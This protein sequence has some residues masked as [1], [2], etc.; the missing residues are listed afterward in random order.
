MDG[1]FH[2]VSGS[3]MS[4]GLGFSGSNVSYLSSSSS[5]P[6]P[7]SGRQRELPTALPPPPP[8]KIWRATPPKLRRRP[9]AAP[10][11]ERRRAVSSRGA[12]AP[13]GRERRQAA[14]SPRRCREHRPS[15]ERHRELHKPRAFRCEVRRR[16]PHV[17]GS[18]ALT[19]V[20]SSDA[21]RELLHQPRVSSAAGGR[22]S[23]AGRTRAPLAMAPAAAT[24]TS[25]RCE[26]KREAGETGA[27][28]PSTNGSV[29]RILR[30]GANPH[31]RGIFPRELLRCRC[32]HPNSR[33]SGAAPL[34]SRGSPT[35]HTVRV[36][37]FTYGQGRQIQRELRDGYNARLLTYIHCCIFFLKKQKGQAHCCLLPTLL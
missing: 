20:A 29:P 22:A 18:R 2:S 11:H 13:L 6:G 21:G 5:S 26:D 9:R 1:S 14:S 36:P 10:E 31:I 4:L 33:G 8:P 3:H 19:P 28:R 34:R 12:R 24:V 32:S 7:R 30:D 15:P 17:R 23:S 35:K 37:T 25:F 16:R 27:R